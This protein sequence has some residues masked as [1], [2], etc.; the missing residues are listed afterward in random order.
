MVF[1]QRRKRNVSFIG[2]FAGGCRVHENRGCGG[3]REKMTKKR[4]GVGAEERVWKW[5]GWCGNGIQ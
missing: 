2:C 5:V 4:K 3:G 1:V